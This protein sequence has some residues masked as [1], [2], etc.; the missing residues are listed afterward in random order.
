MNAAAKIGQVAR[1]TGLS[2]DAIRFYE[3]EGL[4]RSSARTEGG[5]RLFANREVAAL[6]FIRNAQELGFS[7]Q[8]IRELL[9]LQEESLG[10]CQHVRDLL[11]QK[12]Q[13]VQSKI[14]EL[15]RL[16]KSLKRAVRQCEQSFGRA[17]KCR[18]G[19]CPVLDE[20]R[21]SEIAAQ[22]AQCR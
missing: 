13:S 2:I 11:K 17:A 21:A 12:I 1:D 3:K 6:K 4:L 19:C 7:L 5:F 9:L 15:R 16:E 22:P 20:L 8:Q 18:K 14:E 10:A